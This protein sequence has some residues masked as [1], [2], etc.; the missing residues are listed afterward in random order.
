[1]QLLIEFRLSTSAPQILIWV[2]P[3]SFRLMPHVIDVR[4]IIILHG[5]VLGAIFLLLLALLD[6]ALHVES[7]I[8]LAVLPRLGWLRSLLQQ[9]QRHAPTS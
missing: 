1:M 9:M 2:G 4:L 8:L 7:D 5:V 6:E 3:V